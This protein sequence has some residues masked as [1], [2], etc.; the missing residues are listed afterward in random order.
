MVFNRTLSIY[1]TSF[2]VFHTEATVSIGLKNSPRESS[3]SFVDVYF[4][5][6]FIN[7]AKSR[8]LNLTKPKLLNL[9]KSKLTNANPTESHCCTNNTCRMVLFLYI[10]SLVS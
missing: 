4:Q 3:S 1:V 10:H 6:W 5:G 7:L 9:N 8:L 2:S